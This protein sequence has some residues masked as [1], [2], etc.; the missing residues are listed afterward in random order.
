MPA[1]RK[2]TAVLKLKGSY[3]KDPQ[4]MKDRQYEPIPK[5][6]IAGPPKY[7]T[8][9]EKKC[10]KEIVKHSPAMVITSADHELV[11]L[12]ARLKSKFINDWL[13]ASEM[14]HYL[15]CLSQL[16]MAPADRSK[17]S[18]PVEEKEENPFARFANK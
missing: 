17:I 18:L 7:L 5:G 15:R 12:T 10:F 9:D 6:E 13:S 14:G 8:A 11:V 3:K 16:G 1:R 4:R 2:P